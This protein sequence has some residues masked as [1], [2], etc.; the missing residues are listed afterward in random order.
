MGNH[1]ADGNEMSRVPNK[2][3]FIELLFTYIHLFIIYKHLK[4]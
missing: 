1:M 2:Y 3:I 4:L